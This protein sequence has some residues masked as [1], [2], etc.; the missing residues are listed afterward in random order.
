MFI[1]HYFFFPLPHQK[2]RKGRLPTRRLSNGDEGVP[3][4]RG[5]AVARGPPRP[6][7]APA[8]GQSAA[9][10]Q[11]D[12]RILGQV[13]QS[14]RIWGAARSPG[15]GPPPLFPA[16]P[17]TYCNSSALSNFSPHLQP[18]PPHPPPRKL[19]A[20]AEERENKGGK[21]QRAG[22]GE[23]G[24]EGAS[25]P[26]SAQ[27]GDPPRP[28]PPPPPGQPCPPAAER[29]GGTPAGRPGPR[30]GRGPPPPPPPGA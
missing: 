9:R 27:P 26:L 16:P 4:P 6:P 10:P 3:G 20:N 2:G 13:R 12:P 8:S 21:E 1:D 15:K 30:G 22:Q 7:P 11:R 25:S 19:R 29:H 18:P 23:E 17:A 14:H 24:R 5:C 28:P